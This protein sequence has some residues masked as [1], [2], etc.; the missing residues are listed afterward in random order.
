MKTLAASLFCLFLFAGCMAPRQYQPPPQVH[1]IIKLDEKQLGVTQQGVMYAMKDP[2]SAM[3]GDIM[4]GLV[5]WERESQYILLCGW[6]NGKNSFGGYVGFK[7]FM[8]RIDNPH[9]ERPTFRLLE[10]TGRTNRYPYLILDRCKKHGL[11]F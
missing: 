7:P 8:G 6:V 11:E 10:L 3:F 1:T 2:A 5:G 9:G 4:S